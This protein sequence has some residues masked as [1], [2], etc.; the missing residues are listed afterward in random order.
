MDAAVRALD[1]R[2]SR[3]VRLLFRLRGMPER[4]LR[5]DGMQH[6]GFRIL[7][8][9]PGREL[10]LGLIGRFWRPTGRLCRFEADDFAGF[11]EPGWAKAVWGFRITPLDATTTL[12][13]TETRV[14]CTDPA[15][16]RRFRAYWTLIR[17]FSGLVRR[18]A[19]AGIRRD[20]EAAQASATIPRGSAWSRR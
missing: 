6:A 10:V 11:D 3:I 12:L 19:L 16:R 14:H 20:A 18:I 5:L 9:E 13:R 2:R 15:S 4:A 8:D 7:A 1:L 17:P